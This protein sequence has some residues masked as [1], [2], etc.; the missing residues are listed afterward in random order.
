ME[1][2]SVVSSGNDADNSFVGDCDEIP[3]APVKTLPSCTEIHGVE[4]MLCTFDIAIGRNEYARRFRC[5]GR[6]GIEI[7]ENRRSDFNHVSRQTAA[8]QWDRFGQMLA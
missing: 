2:M 4:Q 3:E 7:V 1:Q 8:P 6:N 5:E